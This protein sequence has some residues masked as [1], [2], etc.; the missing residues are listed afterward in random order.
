[1]FSRNGM[2]SE[3]QMRRMLVLSVYASLIFVVPYLSAWLFGESIVPGLATF[4]VLACVYT[5]CIYAF[6][7]WLRKTVTSCGEGEKSI[8]GQVLVLMQVL[9]L[10]IRLAFYICLTIEVLGEGQVPFMPENAGGNG[11]RLLVAV[12]LLLVALYAASIGDRGNGVEKQGRIYELIFWVLFIPLVLVLLFGIPEVDFSVFVP[13]TSTNAGVLLF[14]AYLLL[15]FLLPVENYLLLRPFLQEENADR[16]KGRHTGVA[17]LAAA[18]GTV[19][20]VCILTL[21]MLGIYGVQG[22]GTEEMLTVSIMRYVRLPLGF[23]ERVDVLLVWFFMIGCFVLIGQTLY[24]M[25]MLLSRIFSRAGK[26]WLL[27]VPLVAAIVLAIL[28]P[29]YGDALWVYRIYGAVA[30]VP[31]SFILPMLGVLTVQIC[32]IENQEKKED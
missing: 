1:M 5:A 21:F 13:Q 27:P 19:L 9:R 10:I 12:P 3:K 15:P 31:F 22:A 23:I 29:G 18:L 26:I 24:F 20:L 32:S 14:R 28:L 4:F 7:L 2:I 11:G 16:K 6:S 17:A 25:R 8:A 30:D